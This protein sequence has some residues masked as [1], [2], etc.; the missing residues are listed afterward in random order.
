MYWIVT[1]ERE[2]LTI[3]PIWPRLSWRLRCFH[4]ERPSH[5]R[6]KPLGRDSN[7]GWTE[8]TFNPWW[9][10]TKVSPGCANCYAEKFS[11]RVGYS[12]SG[13]K[14]PIWG[15]HAERRFFGEEH[16]QEPLKWDAAARKLGVMHRVFCGSMCDILEKRPQLEAPRWRAF[17]LAEATPNLLWLFLTK[18]AE[19]AANLYPSFWS[20]R[21]GWPRNVMAGFTL[22]CQSELDARMPHI[23]KFAGAFPGA[24]IFASCEPLLSALDWTPPEYRPLGNVNRND[25]LHYFDWVIG[26]GESGPGARPC[27][28]EWARKL[29]DDCENRTDAGRPWQ[30]TF[31]W[32]QWGDWAPALYEVNGL[33]RPLIG[34]AEFEPVSTSRSGFHPFGDNEGAVRV[35]AAGRTLDGRTWDGVPRLTYGPQVAP[36]EK[37]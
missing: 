20:G 22:E 35:K 27:R 28:V 19:N 1:R 8:H 10:C 6:V 15:E 18:R 21:H 30:L 9:G 17:D 25:W 23:I 12:S 14:F 2:S 37:K 36:L 5:E 3:A 11:K 31:T 29:R 16:W 26:G 34:S 24:Q 13:S 32:K 4:N 33:A 7:I